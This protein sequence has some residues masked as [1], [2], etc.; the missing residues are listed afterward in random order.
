[1]NPD[2]W[3]ATKQITQFLKQ[4]NEKKKYGEK[5]E[6]GMEKREQE[7][8]KEEGGRVGGQE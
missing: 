4:M 2:R 1:M 3:N 8:L 6:R 7:P 5:R